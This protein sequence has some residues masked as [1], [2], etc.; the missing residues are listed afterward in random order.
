MH[1]SINPR[2]IIKISAGIEI[3]NKVAV[4]I[5]PNYEN[6]AQRYL[7]D[8]LES[9]RRQDWAGELKIFITDNRSTAESF[10]FL[11]ETA[12]EVEIIRNKNTTVSPRGTTMPCSWH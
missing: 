2:F 12:P 4:I 9:L 3:M 8:C 7:K 10:A 6:Y 11:K 1:E 5:S